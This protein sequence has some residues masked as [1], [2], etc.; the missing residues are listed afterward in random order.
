MPVDTVSARMPAADAPDQGLETQLRDLKR[1]LKE[2]ERAFA[3]KEGRK[4]E[5]ADILADKA[6]AR[7]YKTYIKLKTAG[8]TSRKGGA[9]PEAES[10]PRS[11]K[12]RVKSTRADEDAPDVG[13]SNEKL[14]E[15]EP[16]PARAKS[17][18]KGNRVRIQ[19][20]PE[21]EEEPKEEGERQG[22]EQDDD[23][24]AASKAAE[25][26]RSPPRR[27]SGLSQAGEQSGLA[28]SPHVDGSP[29]H[30]VVYTDTI[31]ASPSPQPWGAAA[32]LPDNFKLR[33]NTVA[34]GPIS[35]ASLSSVGSSG[36]ASRSTRP[37][38]MGFVNRPTSASPSGRPVSMAA[39]S[40][41]PDFAGSGY[42]DEESSEFMN[43][44]NRKKELDIQAEAVKPHGAVSA[45]E[46]LTRSLQQ[47]QQQQQQQSQ[48]QP[49]VIIAPRDPGATLNPIVTSITVQAPRPLPSPHSALP[50]SPAPEPLTAAQ[51]REYAKYDP[52]VQS[53]DE[54]DDDD[55]GR[56]E[57]DGVEPDTPMNA[58]PHRVAAAEKKQR[59]PKAPVKA[60][61]ASSDEEEE[62]EE[63]GEKAAAPVEPTPPA[64]GSSRRRSK[65]APATAK[66]KEVEANAEDDEEKDEDVEDARDVIAP[67]ASNATTAGT[68]CFGADAIGVATNP[69]LVGVKLFYRLPPEF[70]LRCKLY[71]KKNILDKSHPTFYL[72]NQADESFLL[73]ARKRKKSKSVNYVISSSQQDMSKDSKHY[74]AKLKA[75]FQRTNF[76]LLDARSYNPKID[77]KGFRELACISY[78]KTVLPRE[79]SVAIPATSITE[80][81]DDYSKD[82][83]SDVKTQN[84]SKLL[85]LRNKPPRW[86]EATQSHCLNFG[87]RV[88]QP[89]IKNCQL[90]GS[91]NENFVVMQ[92][93]RCGPDYF[94]LDVRY[95]MTPLEAFAV[96]LTTFDAY[97]NA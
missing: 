49:P 38:S 96:A 68:M 92:F 16:A 65:E 20:P 61:E 23:A 5:K 26:S 9:E 17:A 48:P 40:T 71:R 90:I 41:A 47:Q 72:Y 66:T 19:E 18:R 97:D 94:T 81:S 55:L 37:L 60:F 86:N 46:A 29:S 1:E 3:G 36:S 77:N 12:P 35:T 15:I 42:G 50:T 31:A 79:M 25:A 7:R 75:N 82:I 58:V 56:E 53:T 91:E 11:S 84:T 78:T 89:S 14:E 67:L 39:A 80:L 6:I 76:V 8:D 44:M 85:F 62:Q 2:W 54:D 28:T 27:V 93:G 70:I 34:S 74:V 63:E 59:K 24:D 4:P 45:A 22:R 73:A 83:M 69:S 32:A 30:P 33:R 87:G 43:F 51:L 10:R 64:K 95:P 21:E 57:D 13:S 52:T 88:T